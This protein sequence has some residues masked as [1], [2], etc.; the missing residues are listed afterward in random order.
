VGL[1]SWLLV[2]PVAGAIVIA[3]LP[4]R[5]EGAARV[6]ALLSS[7]GAFVLSLVMLGRFETGQAGFQFAERHE[8]IRSLGASYSIAVDGISLWLVLLTAFLLPICV[9]ASWRIAKDPKRFFVLL[10]VL[11]SATN[12]VF[13][14]T[15]LLLFYVA[16]EAVLIPMYFLIGAWG[17]ER[18]IY[19]AVKFFIYTLLGGLLMLAGIISLVFAA[20]DQIGGITFDLR[21]LEQVSLGMSTQRWIFLAFMAAFAI[22]VP[23]WPLHTWLPDAHTEA[24]TAGSVILAGV[25]LKLGAYGILRYGVGLF[26]AVVVDWADILSILGVIGIL[27]GAIVATM[28]TDL[29]RLVAYSSVSHLGFVVLGIA[30]LTTASVQGASL[31]MVNHGLA[32]GAL[33]LIVGM[34]YERRHSRQIDQLGGIGAAA[35]LLTGAM[36]L[37]TLASIGVPGLNGFVGEFLVLTGTFSVHRVFAIIAVSGV[38]LAALYLLWAY[39]RSFQGP[40]ENPANRISDLNGR[41]RL[42]LAPVLA[43]LIVFGLFPRPMLDRMTPS[44]ERLLNRVQDVRPVPLAEAGE[45]R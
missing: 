16:W 7:L 4:R 2:V 24:P 36:L 30:S 22:K 19:A 1:L 44:I 33:F 8:W 11:A 31:Q 42:L 6:I 26:P 35:P 21:V 25:M 40:L 14:A 3:F 45:S 5:H 23:I 43:L 17:Y 12:L 28:Q 10:L 39:Q 13:L 20:R 34:V 37:A 41:E 27:Y 38:V 9:L 29:K 18:R 15:D 32:T